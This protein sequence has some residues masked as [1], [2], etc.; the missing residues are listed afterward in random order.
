MWGLFELLKFSFSSIIWGILITVFSMVL[1][2]TLIRGWYKSAVFTP[3]SY[4][5]GTVLLFLL[6][7]QC[8]MI[9]GALKI[10]SLS[11]RF[12]TEFRQII[13]QRYQADQD[14][15]LK[16]ADDVIQNVIQEYPV[17]EHYIAGGEFTG[18]KAKDLPQAISKELRSFMWFYILRRLLWC[19]GFVVI[20]A[21]LIIQSISNTYRNNRKKMSAYSSSRHSSRS[22]TRRIF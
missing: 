10:N 19:L 20:G 15:S 18:F 22:M 1:F 12:E 4:L 17:L 21:I 5:I 9:V 14:V 7:F 16:Q 8:T 13:N 3:F 6:M 2:F 11:Q